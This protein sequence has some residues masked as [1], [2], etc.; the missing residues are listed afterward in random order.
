MSVTAAELFR[1]P[2]SRSRSLQHSNMKAS[3]VQSEKGRE[4]CLIIE[5]DTHSILG[6]YGLLFKSLNV[7]RTRERYKKRN[8]MKY[9]QFQ[10]S[11][12]RTERFTQ[13]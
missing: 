5:M 6:S 2:S 8:E 9:F 7:T 1:F 10:I 3:L 11:R 12:M 4:M 13:V